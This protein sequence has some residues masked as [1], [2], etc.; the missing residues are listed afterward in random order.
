MSGPPKTI[1]INHDDYH[2]EHIGRTADGR[3]FFLTTPFE[4][5]TDHNEGCEYIALFFFDMK[6]KFLDARIESFGSRSQM[7]YKHCMSVR[8]QWLAEL[9]PVEYC[10]IEVEPFQIERFNTAFGLIPRGPEDGWTVELHPGNYMAFF[11]PWDSGE[12]DS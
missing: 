12:Y 6:G 7:D 10:R 9:G 1:A 2:A 3:Q 5:A 11:E 8:D 4:P